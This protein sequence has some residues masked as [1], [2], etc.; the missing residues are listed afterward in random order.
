MRETDPCAA[1]WVAIATWCLFTNKKEI[2]F[3]SRIQNQFDVTKQNKKTFFIQKSLQFVVGLRLIF[4][5]FPKPEIN[6]R[7]TI[8][9]L[10]KTLR[11]KQANMWGDMC[12]LSQ[13]FWID[14]DSTWWELLCLPLF[15]LFFFRAVWRS[16]DEEKNK[17][18]NV[19]CNN[20]QLCYISSLLSSSQSLYTSKRDHVPIQSNKF[21]FPVSPKRFTVSEMFP[22]LLQCFRRSLWAFLCYSG[23]SRVSAPADNAYSKQDD[24]ILG[25]SAPNTIRKRNAN[26]KSKF[27]FPHE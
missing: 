24:D 10:R 2:T 5:S 17:Q 27:V 6:N 22:F 11:W 9:N 15:S 4:H 23:F 13:A 12:D 7:R 25:S 26:S 1:W 20:F 18:F 19:M 8:W 14:L 16:Q 21:S 3:P